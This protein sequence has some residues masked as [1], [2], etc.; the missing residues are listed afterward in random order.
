MFS[1]NDKPDEKV[2]KFAVFFFI[3]HFARLFFYLSKIE[4]S[5]FVSTPVKSFV[6]VLSLSL[7]IYR[8][9]VHMPA[10]KKKDSFCRSGKR[11]S[12]KDQDSTK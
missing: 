5:K 4:N 1:V 6:L 12:R 9:S 7:F 2:K 8:E 11:A 3:Q 10:K